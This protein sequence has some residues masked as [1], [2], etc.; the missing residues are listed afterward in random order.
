[1]DYDV[2]VIG[3]GF[4][5]AVSACR[6]AEAGRSVLVLERGREWT[7]DTYPRT[8][9]DR[10]IWDQQNPTRNN[11]WLDLRCFGDMT[12]AAGAGVGGGSLVYANVFVTAKPWLFA[13]GWPA[14]ITYEALQPHYETVG[15]MLGA[16]ELP[17]NQLTSRYRLMREGAEAIGHADRFRKLPLAVSFSEDWHY[18]LDDAHAEHR[19]A[20]WVNE[21]G[22]PQGTCIHCGYCDIGCPVDAKNTLDLNYLAAARQA[23]AQVRALHLVHRIEALEG[24][25]RVGFDIVDDNR[26]EPG[27]ATATQV[28]LAAGSIGSTELLLKQRDEHGTLP[29]LSPR[30]GHGWCANGDFLTPA[31]YADRAVEPTR[32]PTITCAIDFL[33][34]PVDAPRFFVED[35]GFPDVI[36]AS[37]D[38]LVSS[39]EAVGGSYRRAFRLLSRVARGTGPL[40]KVMPWFGQGVDEF[41]IAS[42]LRLSPLRNNI[43][44]HAK[45][46]ITKSKRACRDL[47]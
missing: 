32:G 36:G 7:T 23:G 41:K 19:S 9:D 40:D 33:D 47:P 34:G 35:G 39:A 11:G 24:G 43:L 28:F 31:T 38:E 5:G 30:L 25:Y 10:W 4:G 18:G 14:N 44:T 46:Q 16:R 20:P 21:H 15:R 27:S 37:V 1:M 45:P 12:V 13:D 42:I 2:I 26:L 6:L 22:Q 8:P 29:R 3:S 17:D